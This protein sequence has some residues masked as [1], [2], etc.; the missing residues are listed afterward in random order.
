MI[1]SNSHN[2]GFYQQ[3]NN[4]FDV[5]NNDNMSKFM[6]FTSQSMSNPLLFPGIDDICSNNRNSN[7]I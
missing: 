7:F 6:N 5:I 1:P 2:Y 3:Q 4:N